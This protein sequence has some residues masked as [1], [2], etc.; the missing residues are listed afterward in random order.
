[1]QNPSTKTMIGWWWSFFASITGKWTEK[2]KSDKQMKIGFQIIMSF[3]PFVTDILK[4][5][6]SNSAKKWNKNVQ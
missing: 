4:F 1:M 3:T 2:F 6:K 5:N